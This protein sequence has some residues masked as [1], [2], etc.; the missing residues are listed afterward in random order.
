MEQVKNIFKEASKLGGVHRKRL[1]PAY[2]AYLTHEKFCD[3]VDR[4]S[5]EKLAKMLR[6]LSFL[7]QTKV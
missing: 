2:E 7:A 1:M 5:L 6:I 4:A 3:R